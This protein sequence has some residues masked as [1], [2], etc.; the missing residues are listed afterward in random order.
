MLNLEI[1][2]KNYSVPE[3]YSEVTMEE[4]I[5]FFDGIE[6]SEEQTPE[7]QLLNSTK[8][9]SNIVGISMNE[10]LDIPA[11]QIMDIRNS[12]GFLSEKLE[13]S[14]SDIIIIDSTS[15]TIADAAKMSYR[16]LIDCE[17]VVKDGDEKKNF[18]KLASYLFVKSGSIYDPSEV[19]ELEEKIKKEKV[20]NVIPAI[21]R[22]LLEKTR[23]L[24]DFQHYSEKIEELKS[25]LENIKNTNGSIQP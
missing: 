1:K 17:S 7:E 8:L 25:T 15:Y 18:C 21:L 16:Q 11:M 14:D 12:I 2:G 13:P 24:K 20:S 22:F 3:S 23:L 4:Y 9:I 19:E 6:I 5:R 10:L